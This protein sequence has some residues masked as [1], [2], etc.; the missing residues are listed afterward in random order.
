MLPPGQSGGF[1]RRQFLAGSGAA[2]SLAALAAC[3][4]G[5]SDSRS[6][7]AT[8]TQAAKKGGTLRFGY[9]GGSTQDTLDFQHAV[10]NF[11]VAAGAQIYSSL[12]RGD[13]PKENG[14]IVNSTRPVL[15]ES[16]ELESPTSVVVRL[17]SDLEF[18][19]GKTITANDVLASI[20]RVLDPSN[21][22]AGAAGLKEIDIASSKVVDDRTVRFALSSPNAFIING[23]AVQLVAI[24]P[25]GQ[26]DANNGSGPFKLKNFAPG[27]SVE[28]ERFDN[29]FQPPL[30]DG[31]V[32]QNFADDTAKLNALRS[33]AIDAAGKL[34]PALAKTLGPGFNVLATSTGGFPGIVMD[35]SSD[36]FKDARVRQAFRLMVDRP[37]LRDQLQAGEGELGNDMFAP[38]DPAYPDLPQREQDIDKA[39]SLLKAAGAENLTLDMHTG[40]IANMEVAFAQMAKQAGVT[41]NVKQVDTTTYFAQYYA[42]DPLFTSLW[43]NNTVAGQLSIAIAPGA[44]YP[45][46]HWNN[47][48]YPALFDSAKKDPDEKSRT[49]KLSQIMKLF[50]DD[51][52]Y[53][54]PTFSQQIDATKAN[55]AGVREDPSS[56]SF[57]YFDFTT[58]GFSS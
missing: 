14:K 49:D 29:Y 5:S 51:G 11:A 25:D 43:P 23:F 10:S 32:L 41:I 42:Q 20:A 1:S 50:Y 7:T 40:E 19:N 52:T 39:K 47:P 8:A 6:S 44:F 18:H 30:L 37:A 24:Y 16:V 26:F 12:L 48:D 27:T 4:S 15:A 28:F 54:I 45:E 34:S 57:G 35:A 36:V 31:L 33:G 17:K 9:A 22:G 38:Y 3:G 56:F 13:F 58:V 46:G 2:L 55:V 21:P 53:I